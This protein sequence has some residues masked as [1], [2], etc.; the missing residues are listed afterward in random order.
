MKTTTKT[1]IKNF[2]EKHW[3][4][5]V[6]VVGLVGLGVYEY[7]KYRQDNLSEEEVNDAI[8]TVGNNLAESATD[9]TEEDDWFETRRKDPA[10]QLENGGWITDDYEMEGWT[11]KSGQKGEIVEMVVNDLPIDNMGAFGDDIQKKLTELYPN[12]K[13]ITDVSMIIDL[14]HD[15][16]FVKPSKEEKEE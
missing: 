7:N 2:W 10:R 12:S 14:R 15:P 4:K 5:I 16:D 9:A 6:A 3:Y 1:K 11:T 8:A 13:A